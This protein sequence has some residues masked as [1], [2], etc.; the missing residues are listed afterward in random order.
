MDRAA[1][2]HRRG[3]GVGVNVF[4]A[5]YVAYLSGFVVGLVTAL[6]IIGLSRRVDDAQAAIDRAGK[7]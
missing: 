4:F 6:F 2:A 5:V 1:A 3:R 7:P